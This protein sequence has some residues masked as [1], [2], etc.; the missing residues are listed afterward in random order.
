MAVIVARNSAMI[1]SK[2]LYG[3]M[4]MALVKDEP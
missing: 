4:T 3:L 2:L 1:T